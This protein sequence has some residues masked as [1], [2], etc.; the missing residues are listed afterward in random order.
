[1]SNV[2]CNF[3]PCLAPVDLSVVIESYTA[4]LTWEDSEEMEGTLLGYN[5][6][7]DGVQ[8]N[9]ELL[10][11]KKYLD[12]NLPL[13]TYSY[14][15]Q[16]VYEHC[17]SELTDGVTITILPCEPPTNLEGVAEKNT[18]IITWN[19]PENTEGIELLGYNIYRDE[20]PL[21]TTPFTELK[22]NDE[23]LAN[24]E[25]LYQIAAVY[26][27]CEESEWTEGVT[28]KIDVTA[29]NDIPKT[30]YWIF[31]NPA[32]NELNIKGSVVPNSVRMYNITGQLVYETAACSTDMRISVATMPEGVYFIKIDSDNGSTTQKLIIK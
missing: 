5:V 9:G 27:H 18:A 16:A 10:T 2:I 20:T 25:Y 23:D 1:M 28:V 32:H 15:V 31:P 29:I 8:L 6:L 11:E 19:K 7:R 4:I 24:G 12:E 3:T 30:A 17:E 22:Y 26:N 21:N 14:Q 13:G